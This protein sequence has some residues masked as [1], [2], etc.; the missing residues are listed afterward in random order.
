MGGIIK[1][2]NEDIH[3]ISGFPNDI[4]GWGAEDKALQNRA[5]FYGVKI[6]K[7]LMNDKEHP[8]VRRRRLLIAHCPAP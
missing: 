1:I 7:N 5:E 8:S 3:T 2:R 4:W 6:L